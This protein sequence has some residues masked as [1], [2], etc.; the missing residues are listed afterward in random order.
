[1][2]PN[3]AYQYLVKDQIEHVPLEKLANRVLATSVVP[4]PPG[5]PMLM[6][7]EETGPA[8]GPYLGY[9]R[10]LWAWDRPPVSVTYPASRTGRHLLG[11]V[12]EGK[13]GHDSGRVP[14]ETVRGSDGSATSGQRLR[15]ERR[16]RACR[17]WL[18]RR[19]WALGKMSLTQATM[20][21]A[22]A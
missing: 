22:A 20:L 19:A 17:E 10:A 21:V 1:M 18:K 11:A 2:S 9:L 4:Y 13:C 7:G 14:G 15:P 16:P 8:D 3:E 5:I 12:P 6:P